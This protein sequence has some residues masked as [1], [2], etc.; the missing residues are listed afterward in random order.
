MSFGCFVSLFQAFAMEKGNNLEIF[1]EKPTENLVSSRVS[2]CY[3]GSLGWGT[4]LL[5]LRCE[6]IDNSA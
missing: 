1:R 2:M 4:G 6:R 5:E 3:S